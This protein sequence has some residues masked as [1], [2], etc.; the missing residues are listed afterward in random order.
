MAEIVEAEYRD[1]AFHPLSPID[2]PEGSRVLIVAQN[3]EL[4]VEVEAIRESLQDYLNGERGVD[5]LSLVAHLTASM[6]SKL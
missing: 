5:A 6:A 3:A 4:G 2:L 1:G